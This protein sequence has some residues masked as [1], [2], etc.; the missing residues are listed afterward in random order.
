MGQLNV[1]ATSSTAMEHDTERRPT[2]DIG[3]D[4]DLKFFA[5]SRSSEA[6]RDATLP[7]Y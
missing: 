3:T 6:R 5:L 1:D 2:C 7:T 4:L